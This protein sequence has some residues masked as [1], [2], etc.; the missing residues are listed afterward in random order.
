MDWLQA[1][2]FWIV[3]TMW[4]AVEAF[5]GVKGSREDKLSA[6]AEAAYEI[7]KEEH[8]TE[9]TTVLT[10]A[11]GSLELMVPEWKRKFDEADANWRKVRPKKRRL[12]RKSKS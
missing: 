8:F 10:K 12:L 11:A 1:N 5:R 7:V 9:M 6:A 3:P 4:G 2:L